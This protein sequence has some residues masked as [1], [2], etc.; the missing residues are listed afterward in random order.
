MRQRRTKGTL[1]GPDITG[2]TIHRQQ[3]GPTQG[4]LAYLT[5]DRLDQRFISPG[6]DRP[7]QPQ[8]RRDHHGHR[9]PN[10]A[11]LRFRFDFIRLHL[12]QIQLTIGHL[13]LM[14]ALT[15][16]PGTLPPVLHRPFVQPKGFHNR[17][18]RTTIHQQGNHQQN[19]FRVRVQA[20][21]DA[22]LAGYKRLAAFVTDV[23]LFLLA[24][25]PDVPFTFLTSCMTAQIRA[26][27]F[28]WVHLASSLFQQQDF[29]SEP[30]FF[31]PLPTLLWGA[32]IQ[33]DPGI[34]TVMKMPPE[35]F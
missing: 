9:D 25:H 11:L 12:P 6:A 5:S 13:R 19:G 10:T 21:E 28:L 7:A 26:K 2:Q 20:V 15:M 4:H 1:E 16:L 17:L 30:T 3:H 32:T 33:S 8:P 18:Q 29:A 27:Y 34:I 35:P 14:H 24:L 31:Q 22:A 23:A